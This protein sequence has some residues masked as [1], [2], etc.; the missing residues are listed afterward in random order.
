[1][2]IA[3]F[4]EFGPPHGVISCV[5][6][7]D[8][9][10]PV[11]DEVLIEIEAFPINPADLLTLSGNYAVRPSLPA[12]LGAEAVGRVVKIGQKV[13]ELSVGDRVIPLGRENWVQWKLERESSV[14]KLPDLDI[15]QAAMLKVNPATAWFMLHN[16]R[17]LKEGDALIQNAANSGV[18]RTLIKLAESKGIKTINIVRRPELAS[19]LQDQYGAF[20]VLVSD[21][22]IEDEVRT[23]TKDKSL[24]LAIDAIG[25]AATRLLANCLQPG[26]IVINY[27]LL[28]GHPCQI[29]S[30]DLI[31]REIT[32]TGFW[33]AKV[34]PQ[35][36]LD[37]LTS[38]YTE[39]AQMM[40]EGNLYVPV[41]QTYPIDDIKGAVAH[42]ERYGRGGKILVLPNG[43]L[44]R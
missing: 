13:E 28:S 41:E 5:E 30:Y 40:V 7:D 33:L 12:T 8:P 24:L 2:K 15:Y 43:A 37:Q 23:L 3:Q 14:I 4:R 18:G 34:L 31:F 27:G 21:D 32:L 29:D 6:V 19:L 22:N 25:D 1:M 44:Q 11:N 26:G 39:L 16:Y 35:T 36:P 17:T 9:S 38:M 10:E 20:S 42:A